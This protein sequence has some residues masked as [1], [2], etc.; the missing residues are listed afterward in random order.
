MAACQHVGAVLKRLL[1]EVHVVKERGWI[2]VSQPTIA[3]PRGRMNYPSPPFDQ[4]PVSEEFGVTLRRA[5]LVRT[6]W[7]RSL[8]SR[9]VAP[10]GRRI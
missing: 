4:N 7:R 6:S 2:N 3:L 10:A 5:E 1:F 9:I 8:T